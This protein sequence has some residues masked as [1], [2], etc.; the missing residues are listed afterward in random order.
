[1]EIMQD[2]LCHARH[3]PETTAAVM[4][5]VAGPGSGHRWPRESVVW[6]VL[7]VPGM[8][9]LTCLAGCGIS[10][11]MQAQGTAAALCV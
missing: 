8:N 6:P 3:H 7:A 1:M 11:A 2:R 9:I 10:S 4:S 5:G